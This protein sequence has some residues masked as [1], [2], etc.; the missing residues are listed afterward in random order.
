MLFVL[1]LIVL[2]VQLW[3]SDCVHMVVF[4][5]GSV[6]MWC[7]LCV[8]MVCQLCVCVIELLCGVGQLNNGWFVLWCGCVDVWYGL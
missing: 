7:V 2:M 4:T 6:Y 3:A 1:L 5:C 8:L